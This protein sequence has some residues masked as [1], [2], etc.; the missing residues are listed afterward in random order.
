MRLKFTSALICLYL[1][2]LSDGFSQ[3]SVYSGNVQGDTAKK[4]SKQEKKIRIADA[5]YGQDLPEFIVAFEVVP[6]DNNKCVMPLH[7]II[8]E[9]PVDED[10][11]RKIQIDQE[12]TSWFRS[13]GSNSKILGQ[14]VGNDDNRWKL[15]VRSK[16][17][18][19]KDNNPEFIHTNYKN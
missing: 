15:V 3:N 2:F 6:V 9:L 17:I 8:F 7:T 10:Y 16:R 14:F 11:F 13:P 1:I 5:V 18:Q 12:V 19:S 4:E